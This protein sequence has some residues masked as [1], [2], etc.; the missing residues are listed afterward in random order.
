[1]NKDKVWLVTGASSGIGAGIVK[2]ALEAGDRVVATARNVEKLQAAIGKS[3]SD[4]L[5]FVALDVTS[6]GQ[7]RKAVATAVEKF[8]RIDV[9]VNNAGYS[10]IGTFES[11]S[12]NQ[13][14]EQIATN[15]WGTLHVV[16]AALP[17]LRGQRGGHI[18]N[19]SSTAGVMGYA[20]CTAYAAS[21]FAVEGLTL[22]LAQE[23]EKFGIKVTLVEPG[24]F[25]TDLLAPQS[26]VFGEIAVAGYDSPEAVRTTWQG[27]NGTQSGDPA[28]LGQALVTVAAM[29]TPPKQFYAGSDAVSAATADLKA[30]LAEVER[31]QSLSASTDG[32]F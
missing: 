2:A 6:E 25:R 19:V 5:A 17:T 30:R 18:I 21:K 7:A 4:R 26:V 23:V 32:T 24:F 10:V 16:H 15:F 22:S 31:Y 27:Y 1:M 29:E 8:G 9:L 3:A 11:L 20:T 12:K 28:K 13:I 14:E